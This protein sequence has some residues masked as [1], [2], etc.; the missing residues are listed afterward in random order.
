M[1]VHVEE[2]GLPPG[3]CLVV[4]EA[5]LWSPLY[6]KAAH[7]CSLLTDWQGCMAFTYAA[8]SGQGLGQKPR[9]ASARSP[10]ESHREGGFSLGGCRGNRV[11]GLWDEDVQAP[12][13]RGVLA[14]SLMCRQGHWEAAGQRALL[15]V[16]GTSGLCFLP[17]F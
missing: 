15:G 2:G 1:S 11:C 16:S 6:G 14:D 7:P 9:S 10:L 8:A 4:V 5:W 3:H 12:A 17:Q 13:L